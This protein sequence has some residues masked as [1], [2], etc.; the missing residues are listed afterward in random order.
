MTEEYCGICSIAYGEEAH[1]AHS[2]F[3]ACNYHVACLISYA[4]EISFYQTL[5]CP[6]CHTILSS[7]PEGLTNDDANS[8][9]AVFNP[10]ALLA[11]PDFKLGL[12]ALKAKKTA[13]GV[14]M[15]SFA[16]VRAAAM[17]EW[18]QQIAEQLQQLRAAQKEKIAAVRAT[19][20]HKAF[21]AKS[22]AFEFA[23]SQ[24]RAKYGLCRHKLN[25]F[26]KRDTWQARWTLRRLRN[27]R[28]AFRI[29]I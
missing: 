28:W 27:F 14:A 8:E 10:D 29:L 9:T 7:S 4:H 20:E 25:H 17:A 11:K 5:E 19:P 24:F 21:A 1:I 13:R 22:R 2:P 23:K 12:K 26:L 3:C 16:K 18:R 6:N 15:R